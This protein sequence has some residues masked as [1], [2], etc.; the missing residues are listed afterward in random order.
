MVENTEIEFNEIVEALH[1]GQSICFSYRGKYYGL[2]IFKRDGES[3]YSL[4]LCYTGGTEKT[5][6]VVFSRRINYLGATDHPQ[7]FSDNYPTGEIKTILDRERVFDGKNLSGILSE[8][9]GVDIQ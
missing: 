1:F 7:K 6:H 2:E 4:N 9:G 8:A 3:F 5:G